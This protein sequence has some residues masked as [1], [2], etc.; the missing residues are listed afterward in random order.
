MKDWR[1]C[2]KCN[3]LF[4]G[5]QASK[6]P[7]PAG[8]G[9]EAQ[10][11]NFDLRHDVPESPHSQGAWRMCRHCAVMFFDGFPEKGTCPTGAAHERGRI[12]YVLAHDME[13]PPNHQSEWRF[14]KSCDGEVF[15]RCRP[16]KAY[17]PGGPADE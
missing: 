6:G 2:H 3:G 16:H 14:C 17:P 7:C 13:A 9:H 15:F 8:G 5:G 10:G 12:T 11:L 1:F 4:L